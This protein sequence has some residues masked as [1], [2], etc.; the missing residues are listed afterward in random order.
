MNYNCF[1]H[2]S[3]PLL[4]AASQNYLIKSCAKFGVVEITKN[5]PFWEGDFH[6]EMVFNKFYTLPVFDIG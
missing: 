6:F 4:A 5:P 3:N 2:H 1:I